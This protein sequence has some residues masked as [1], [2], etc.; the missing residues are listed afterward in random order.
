LSTTSLCSRVRRL[1]VI[2]A[3]GSAVT[4]VDA[5]APG[6]SLGF[7]PTRQGE[8]AKAQTASKPLEHPTPADVKAFLEHPTPLDAYLF[9]RMNRHKESRSM[10]NLFE[11]TLN[12]NTP[13]FNVLEEYTRQAEGK[14]PEWLNLL[15]EEVAAL[16][17]YANTDA[18]IINQIARGADKAEFEDYHSGPGLKNTV[19]QC[20]L[21]KKDML[22]W[23]KFLN[24][25]L[26]KMPSAAPGRLYRVV[27][28]DAEGTPGSIAPITGFSSFSEDFNVAKCFVEEQKKDGIQPTI[29]VMDK[30]SSGRQLKQ[31][32]GVLAKWVVYKEVVF[33]VGTKF[34]IEENEKVQ[35][36]VEAL[37]RE[38]ESFLRSSDPS[39]E[40]VPDFKV[41]VVKE[42]PPGEA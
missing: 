26:N 31:M 16:W 2:L 15:P 36:E 8:E 24:A 32:G 29:F 17:S 7:A 25:G 13:Q 22:P 1:A 18:D 21:T 11:G 41:L 23:I 19:V 35:R 3:L 20:S 4:S 5:F 28:F 40:A 38:S 34:V 33:S 39:W 30:H 37:W 14:V 9:S 42:V 27:G 6:D 10:L 12:P